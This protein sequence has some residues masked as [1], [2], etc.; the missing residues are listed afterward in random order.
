MSNRKRNIEIIK[1]PLST[2]VDNRPQE[3]PRMPRMYLELLENKAKIKQDLINSEYQHD[4]SQAPSMVPAS[5]QSVSS[6]GSSQKGNLNNK[7]RLID[8]RSDDDRSVDERSVDER[9]VDER[10]IN[11]RSV[12]ER[13]VDERSI[14]KK[15]IDKISVG[16]R[17]A[18]KRSIDKRSI[19]KRSIDIPNKRNLVLDIKDDDMS[20]IGS[21]SP[22]SDVPDITKRLTDMLGDDTDDE[23]VKSKHKKNKK[24]KKSRKDKYSK[25]RD[26]GGHSISKGVEAPSFAELEA[27]GAYIPRKELRNIDTMYEADKNQDD[28]KRELLFKFELLR[29]SYPTATIPEYSVHTE[30]KMMLNS[31]EDCVRRLSLDSSVDNFK[32]Y[33]IYAFMGMEFVLGKFLKL[34]MEGFTQQQIVSMSS[35]DKLLIELGEK[36]YLPNG[37]AW[38][39]EVRLLGLVLMNTAFFV[40]SKM[41]M[42]NT[43]VNLMNMMNS[44]KGKTTTD[45]KPKRKMRGPDVDFEDLP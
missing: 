6:Y 4:Y 14:D 16:E 34:D 24:D 20:S 27:K 7:S 43:S 31:Y 39:V 12:D 18:D 44:M 19:D 32:Q 17:S 9:S 15:S 41:I 37:S 38:S 45:D 5:P 30:Y 26:K 2:P 3:F 13:S 35:Y 29:K 23:S 10:S 36:S 25:Q 42:K 40:V 28:L 22:G 11:D 8:D 33:L 21:K 1:V